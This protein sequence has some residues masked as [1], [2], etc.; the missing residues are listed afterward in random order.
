MLEVKEQVHLSFQ[1]LFEICIGSIS[2]RLMRSAVTVAIIVLAIA[3]LAQIMMDGYLGRAA[4]D[5]AHAQSAQHTAFSRFLSK[6]T[7]LDT[8]EHLVRAFASTRPGTAAWT[9][10]QRWGGF[11][12]DQV[13]AFVSHARETE[14]YLHFFES[15]PSGRRALLVQQQ[16][17]LHVLDWL[18][19]ESN[20]AAFSGHLGQMK[21]VRLPAGMESLRGFLQ[22][23]SDFREQL[24]RV[25]RSYAATIARI[26]ELSEGNELTKALRVSVAAGHG[27]EF[28]AKLAAL[29]FSVEAAEMQ[30]IVRGLEF[31]DRLAWA[32]GF[33]KSAPVR[34]G[35]NRQFHEQFSP[36]PALASCAAS[37]SRIEWVKRTL[38]EAGMTADFD[39][40]RFGGIAVE[41]RDRERVLSA[42]QRLLG[43]YGTSAT[44]SERTIWLIV[45]SF[46]VCVVGIANAMLMSVLERFKEIA[47]MKCLGARNQTIAFL[48]VTESMIIG[49]V[50][51]ILGTILGFLIVFLRQGIGYG[52]LLFERL[53][54]GDIGVTFVACFC[55]SLLLAAIAAIYPAGV[56]S[57]MAPMEAMRVD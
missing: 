50:G 36:G 44:L 16:E 14:T 56:A 4:R 8:D 30:D 10:L 43:R 46:L 13:T 26:T 41:Y 5:T 15:I 27:E 6:A 19:D 54:W 18:C 33:L 38:S 31:Q 53:P 57:R 49:L 2:Y 20:F 11:T 9:N 48:F 32:F 35:W 12:D 42:A 45:V 55:C 40:T 47:T 22:R 25:K 39:A 23:W 24:D 29:G 34:T 3:F 17:G 51:G 1:R 52:A 37:P 28:F 7:H 21:S